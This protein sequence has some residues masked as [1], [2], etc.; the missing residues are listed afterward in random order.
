TALESGIGVRE[1]PGVVAG[2]WVYG[3]FST[4]IG[5]GGKNRGWD[6]LV[7][8]KRAFDEVVAAGALMGSKLIEVE[9]QLAVCEGSDWFWW[10]GDY[11]PASTVSNFER[12]YRKHLSNLY[13]LIDREPPE[14]LSRAFTHGKGGST[15]G[16]R[17]AA[18]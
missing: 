5:D 17:Y 16:R 2:S 13:Q 14:Y 4:W 3:T 12:L 7:D 18:K 8:A 6:M 11:N 9:R 15:I 10:F 1:L